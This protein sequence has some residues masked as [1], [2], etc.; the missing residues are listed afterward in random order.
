[1]SPLPYYLFGL[2]LA[3]ALSLLALRLGWLNRR[4]AFAAGLLGTLV[5][6]AFG[7]WGS[8]L[9]V[10]FV[11]VGSLAV[12]TNPRSR[13]RG[14]RSAAQVLANGLPALLGGLACGPVF[15]AGSLAAVTADTLASELGAFS[16]YAW[17]LGRG[18]VPTGS[19][20]AV[21]LPGTL[22]LPTGA[23][24]A[25]LWAPARGLPFSA[26]FLGGA[27][28]AVCDTITGPLEERLGWWNNNVNNAVA[29]TAG[30]LIAC[31]LT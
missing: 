16:P 7:L 14:G 8:L 27:L 29:A 12:R 2:L 13:D 4:A 26:V 10:F 28:G 30:G 3:A 11:A 19:N 5:W 1:M 18:R 23:A 20:A 31:W 9:L 6:A 21:S 17:R 15:F 25:A 22:A 24:L